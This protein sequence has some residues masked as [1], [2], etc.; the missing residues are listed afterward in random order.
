MVCTHAELPCET[1]KALAVMKKK[2][3]F[4]CKL[5]GNS[6]WARRALLKLKAIVLAKPRF[7][8]DEF[9]QTV[10][11]ETG[12]LLP[13]SCINR[14]LKKLGFSL[15]VIQEKAREANEAERL[16]FRTGFEFL[17]LYHPG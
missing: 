14:A 10:L 1:R 15:L 4:R 8:L 11:D 9:V 13:T 16:Q 17:V 3:G 2:A 5:H 7:F 6:K 12:V